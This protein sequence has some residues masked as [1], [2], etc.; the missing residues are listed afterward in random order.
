M[1]RAESRRSK[2]SENKRKLLE[3]RLRGSGASKAPVEVVKDDRLSLGMERLWFLHCLDPHNPAYHVYEEFEIGP[4][5]NVERFQG[6]WLKVVERHPMMRTTLKKKPLRRVLTSTEQASCSVHHDV[7]NLVDFAREFRCRPFQPLK[8]A[9]VRASLVKIPGGYH[10]LVCCHHL[11]CDGWS[12]NLLWKELAQFYNSP[13]LTLPQPRASYDHIVHQQRKA[14]D[15]ELEYWTSKL[16]GLQVTEIPPD[17]SRQTSEVSRCAVQSLALN[18]ESLRILAKS[19]NTTPYNV[20]LTCWCT[21]LALWSGQ[22]DVSLATPMSGRQ[23][24]AYQDVFGFFVNTIILRND[25]SGNPSFS[26]LLKRV[27]EKTLDSWNHQKTP[28]TSIVRKLSPER[29]RQRNPLYS[30][31]FVHQAKASA[32]LPLDGTGV[33]SVDLER[34]AQGYEMELRCIEGPQETEIYLHYEASLYEVSTVRDLLDHLSTIV[35]CVSADPSADFSKF[36]RLPDKITTHISDALV[37]PDWSYEPNTLHRMFES[38]AANYP[39]RLAL[40]SDH[41]ETNYRSLNEGANRLAHKLIKLGVEPGEVIA[42]ALPRG[43]AS[44]TA[45]LAILKSGACCLPLDLHSSPQRKSKR[46]SLAKVR[47]LIAESEQESLT[48]V[49]WNQANQSTEDPQVTVSPDST[50]FVLHTSSSTGEAKAVNCHHLGLSHRIAY[51]NELY[52]F[53]ERGRAAHRASLGFVDSV[54]ELFSP[55]V[56]GATV[57]IFP[58]LESLRD[59]ADRIENHQVTRLTLVPA[60]LRTMLNSP[61]ASQALQKLDLI[62]SSG[63][64][65][66]ASL[67]D[68]CHRTLPETKLVNLYGSTEA[69]GDVTVSEDSSLGR[70][71]ANHR[72]TI[73]DS[74]G[75]PVAPGAVGE[76]VVEGPGVSHS[77]RRFVTGDIVCLKR[78]MTLRFIGRKDRQTKIRGI[79]VDLSYLEYLTLAHPAVEQC[80]ALG[81]NDSL[82]LIWSGDTEESQQVEDWVQNHIDARL[83][84]QISALSQIPINSRGKPDFQ[85]LSLTQSL[86]SEIAEPNALEERIL[87]VWRKVLA[88][89]ELTVE[90]NF[91]EVG[92]D[93]LLG[94]SLIEALETELERAIK[95]SVLFDAPTVQRMA[96]LFGNSLQI[97]ELIRIRAAEGHSLILFPPAACTLIRYRDIV[98]ALP[99]SMDIRGFEYP[100][101]DMGRGISAI[102]KPWC[103]EL[104]ASTVREP[105]YLSGA[106]LGGYFAIEMAHQ[107]TQEGR[108]VALVILIDTLAQSYQPRK[109]DLKYWT[110]WGWQRVLSPSKFK[111]SLR[112]FL[113]RQNENLLKPKMRKFRATYLDHIQAQV[114]YYPSPLAVEGYSINSSERDARQNFDQQWSPIFSMGYARTTLPETTHTGLIQRVDQGQMVARALEKKLVRTGFL[115]SAQTQD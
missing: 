68:K 74:E 89:K 112:D 41:T 51:L 77:S 85:D 20:L 94:L 114:G 96:A 88:A 35:E 5:L 91:F 102:V 16:A 84:P 103:Q 109:K 57:V 49:D 79:R 56:S 69:S 13:T 58:E 97:P 93:S 27:T 67:E 30:V 72:L 10:F 110:E 55:L 65:L 100:L 34:E 54:T 70:P 37:G 75:Q 21:V 43:L 22:R 98:S 48:L 2:L 3:A 62:I 53:A 113:I 28:L 101:Y 73:V 7:A 60:L 115:L 29:D 106:C 18:S 40:V 81:D 108:R 52:P 1:D 78:D 63:S 33:R 64:A 83:R 19:H 36:S 95:V 17:H 105:Y 24:P 14:K 47:F 38:V 45:I 46:T 87:K 107:L 42:V 15:S 76:L 25:L 80:I 32:T 99:Q 44:V 6:A 31:V 92:G 23:D 8:K 11:V 61:L 26:E 9:M 82:H 86:K 12:L 90:D 59:M 39:N 71:L 66:S 104:I 4:T 50:A 111:R